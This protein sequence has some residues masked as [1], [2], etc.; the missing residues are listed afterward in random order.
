MK[1]N[2][3]RVWRRMILSKFSENICATVYRRKYMVITSMLR[4]FSMINDGLFPTTFRSS[5]YQDTSVDYPEWEA[6][7]GSVEQSP[8][9]ASGNHHL[10]IADMQ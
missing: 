2:A 8:S 7:R 3:D 1:I 6:K 9:P 10:Q 4:I 5:N